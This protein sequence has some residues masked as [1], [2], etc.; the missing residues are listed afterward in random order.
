MNSHAM[1]STFRFLQRV[2]LI[3][4]I[5]LGLH[6]LHDAIRGD[7]VLTAGREQLELL[8]Q[9][10][11]SNPKLAAL[12]REMDF[13][14]R[15]TYFQAHDKRRFGLRLL[16]AGLLVLCILL[17]AERFFLP[18]E[19]TVP[20]GSSPERGS[21]GLIIATICGVVGLLV[22]LIYIRRS[23]DRPAPAQPETAAIAETPDP[24]QETSVVSQ[25]VEAVAKPC[26]YDVARPPRPCCKGDGALATSGFATSSSPCG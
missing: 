1:R 8:K 20:K 26:V 13:I 4:V 7:Q 16:G 5:C 21:G 14:Y 6:V 24:T 17:G 3:F 19:L 25:P 18:P 9:E 15:S 12:A 11:V 23:P 10:D 22:V 2:A